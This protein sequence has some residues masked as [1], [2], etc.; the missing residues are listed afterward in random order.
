MR[1]NKVISLI[2]LLMVSSSVV[3]MFLFLQIDGTV[4]TL[5]EYGV[6]YDSQWLGPYSKLTLIAFGLLVANTVAA[7]YGVISR[8]KPRPELKPTLICVREE[9]LTFYEVSSRKRGKR[10]VSVETEVIPVKVDKQPVQVEVEQPTSKQETGLAIS[11][12][13]CTRVFSRPLL[14]LDF[15]SGKAQLINVCPYCRHPFHDTLNQ[16]GKKSE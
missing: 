4:K 5:D 7:S 10:F 3:S 1:I 15:S 11:C 8:V 12:P 16:Q 6:S 9:E 13:N 14:V 2:L